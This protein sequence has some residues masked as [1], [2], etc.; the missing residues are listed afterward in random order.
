MF[1]A[2]LAATVVLSVTAQMRGWDAVVCGRPGR[3]QVWTEEKRTED[4]PGPSFGRSTLH[5]V[6]PVARCPINFHVASESLYCSSPLTVCSEA[7][8]TSLSTTLG[9]FPP[10]KIWATCEAPSMLSPL[11]R[12]FWSSESL[13]IRESTSQLLSQSGGVSSF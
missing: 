6:A 11:T 7:M 12:S 8:M 3:S 2:S 9:P 5:H 10:G 1:L 13:M 4:P